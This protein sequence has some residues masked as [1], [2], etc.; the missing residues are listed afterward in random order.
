[1]PQVFL[2]IFVLFSIFIFCFGLFFAVLFA[3]GTLTFNLLSSVNLRLFGFSASQS[4]S[5]QFDISRMKIQ[6]GRWV[7]H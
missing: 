4:V 7:F 1:M 6:E 2:A 3:P 5:T